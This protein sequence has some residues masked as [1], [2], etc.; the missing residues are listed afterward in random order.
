MQDEM[1]AAFFEVAIKYQKF[2]AVRKIERNRSVRGPA[3]HPHLLAA[4][5]EQ[6]SDFNTRPTLGIRVRECLSI[7]AHWCSVLQIELP[8]LD[9]EQAARRGAWG[10]ARGGRIT[11]IG[12]GRIIAMLVLKHA[13]EHNKLLTAA[14]RMCR[15]TAGRC[16]AND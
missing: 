16:I 6:Q 8:Q 13:V 5:I 4:V 9:E 10:V 15:E 12:T 14:M 3:L 2:A 1:L 7:E 11:D